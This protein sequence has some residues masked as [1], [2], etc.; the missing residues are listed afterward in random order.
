MPSTR[1]KKKVQ[2]G[3][4]ASKRV[5]NQRANANKKKVAEKK[6]ISILLFS[7]FM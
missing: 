4:R 6:V 2:Q 1:G 3:Q 7:I 5:A